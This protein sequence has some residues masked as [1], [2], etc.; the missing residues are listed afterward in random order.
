MP[1]P[2]LRHH[3]DGDG[4]DDGGDQ[5]GIAHPGHAALTA[6]VRGHPLQGHHRHRPSV[7]GDL[8]LLGGNDVHDDAALEHLGQPRLDL[9]GPLP[10]VHPLGSLRHTAI[11][12]LAAGNSGPT[13]GRRVTNR[14]RTAARRSAQREDA[15]TTWT[16]NV[17]PRAASW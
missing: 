6:N 17:R 15:V 1:D 14:S 4:L 10:I 11:L 5:A 13:R 8:G 12:P 3:G 2:A 16:P 7:L 9:P